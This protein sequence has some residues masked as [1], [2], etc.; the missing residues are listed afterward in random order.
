MATPR[1]Q[2]EE[3]ILVLNLEEHLGMIAGVICGAL[4][5][6]LIIFTILICRY[7]HYHSSIHLHILRTVRNNL[8]T[9]CTFI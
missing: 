3:R 5:L 9:Y 7:G 6:L 8:W 1:W 4:G 2:N